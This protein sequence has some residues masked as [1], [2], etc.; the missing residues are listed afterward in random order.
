[1][2][3]ETQALQLILDAVSALPA[4]TLPFHE[5]PHRFSAANVAATVPLPGFDNSAMDGYAVVAAETVGDTPLQVI[6]EQP[7]GVDQRLQLL[8]GTAIRI[9]TGAPIPAGA[10]AIIMQ[11]DVS[12]QTLDEGIAI[13]CTE[14]VEHGENIRLTGCDLCIGQRI[15]SVGDALTP[16]RLGLLASQGLS[17][18]SA[19]ATPGLAII[20]TGD[21]LIPAG[22]PLQ[23]G[24]LYNSN[25]TM[26]AALA[27][28]IQI[29]DVTPLHVPDDLALTTACLRDAIE[30]HEV[31]LLAGGVSVGD[32][33][34]VKAA[35]SA[36][37][38]QPALWRVKVKPGKP[39]LFCKADRPGRSPCYIFGLPGN[40]VSA[41]VTYQ[42]FVRPA[43]LKIMGASPQA[44]QL[45]KFSALL[46]IPQEN[47]GDRPH[48]VRGQY[49]EGRFTP[50]GVQQ[51]HALYG[52]S[53]ANAL[54]RQGPMESY[55]EGTPIEVLLTEVT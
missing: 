26:L 44:Q 46:A 53:Q 49:H 34:H 16:A 6:G 20:T 51:S 10:D 41:Y 35:L 8:P 5:A 18:I 29:S 31:I 12:V 27:R 32:H 47:R 50:L 36:L 22:Q 3:T 15:L 7:A 52:L 4:E 33:D 2:L 28:S 42:I 37:G 39:L 11:E 30:N 38:I 24:Q 45:V 55:A 48:Y 25:A 1:M 13:R 23:P 19:T 40:P 43:L 14:P 17:H 21:E 54:M 9:F